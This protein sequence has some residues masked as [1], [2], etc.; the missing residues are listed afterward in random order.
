[1]TE[2]PRAYVS[3]L[4]V[5]AF[6]FDV[7]YELEFTFP[8]AATK[9]DFEAARKSGLESIHAWLN[10][11]TAAPALTVEVVDKLPWKDYKTKEP[12]GPG[13]TGWIMWDRDGGGAL[14]RVIHEAPEQRLKLGSYEFVFSGKEKQFIGRRVVEPEEAPSHGAPQ[15]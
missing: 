2:K 12:M 11:K 7:G 9:D 1:M 6:K 8:T 15:P 13:H 4:V 3:R 14:A 5:K 10:E